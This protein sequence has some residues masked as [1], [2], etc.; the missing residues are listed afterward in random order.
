MDRPN[1]APECTYVLKLSP[2]CP[3][4]GPLRGRLEHVISGR[5]HDFDDGAALLECLGHEQRQIAG[6]GDDFGG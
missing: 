6:G 5:R 4:G 3:G 1:T 2:P